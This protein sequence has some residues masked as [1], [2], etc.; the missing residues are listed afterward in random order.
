MTNLLHRLLCR[1]M[2]LTTNRGLLDRGTFE[3]LDL[4]RGLLKRVSD[5]LVPYTLEGAPLV[6]P[7]SHEL[8]FVRRALPQY[9]SNVG[10]LAK[11]VH[12]KYPDMTLVDIGANVGDTLAI[13]RSFAHFPVLCIEG[14][15][16]FFAILEE[17]VRRAGFHEVELARTF[18][19]STSGQLRAASITGRGTGRLQESQTGKQTVGVQRLADI[20]HDHPRFAQF[21]M[22]KID[23]DGFDCRILRGALDVLAARRPVIFFEYDPH[24][25]AQAGDAGI[26]IFQSLR[27]IGY[28]KALAYE[29]N[30]D[31]LLA[32]ELDHT[33]QW[34][35]LHRF[36]TGRNGQR[37]LD[38]CVFPSDDADLCETARRSELNFFSR[39]RQV[40]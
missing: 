20:L 10:R 29:N 13:L 26:D 6:V 38:L 3:L 7:F 17:N 18:V 25:L 35:D 4:V 19:S 2:L 37:Y 1:A 9:A 34:E 39:F 33:Q 22:L 23:T 32:G 14:D 24:F 5:P 36:Y 31:Y 40:A 21:R 30:G 11:L 12:E 8:P 27:N 15:D 16:R 28:V